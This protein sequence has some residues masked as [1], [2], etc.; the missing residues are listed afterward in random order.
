MVATHHL[1]CCQEGQK[2]VLQSLIRKVARLD[3]K[4][5]D[6]KVVIPLLENRC[7]LLLDHGVTKLIQRSGQ[8][9][10]DFVH[11]PRE[12]TNKWQT[13]G[14]C[15]ARKDELLSTR[16]E[17]AF[18]DVRERILLLL[19]GI[20]SATQTSNANDVECDLARPTVELDNR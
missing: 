17:Q 3:E 5:Q 16:L 11:L 9:V 12:E 8:I 1:P 13:N 14:Q 19:N 7:L 20:K 6:I 18:I 15:Q 10:E 2:L 4:R